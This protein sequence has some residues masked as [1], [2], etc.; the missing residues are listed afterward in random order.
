M[1]RRMHRP[2]HRQEAAPGL[3][4]PAAFYLASDWWCGAFAAP[5]GPPRS[6]IACNDFTGDF[7]SGIYLLLGGRRPKDFDAFNAAKF[8]ISR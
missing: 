8:R 4:T 1:P 7:F 3:I 6:Q 2:N 5:C